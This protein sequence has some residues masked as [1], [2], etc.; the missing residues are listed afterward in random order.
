MLESPVVPVP[1]VPRPELPPVEEP[2]PPAPLFDVLHC[3]A[4]DV[5]TQV[6]HACVSLGTQLSAHCAFPHA[7]ADRQVP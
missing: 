3:D 4:Q 1:P 7:H 2:P 6:P 5:S